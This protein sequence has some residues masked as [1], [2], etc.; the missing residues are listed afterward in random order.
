MTLPPGLRMSLLV[1]VLAALPLATPAQTVPNSGQI[2]QQVQ[3]HKPAKPTARPKLKVEQPETTPSQSTTPFQ[4]K[5]IVVEGASVV[6]AGTLYALVADGEGRRLT[7]AQLQ[8]L[9]GRIS[10]YYHAHGYLLARAIVPAQ[11]LDDGTVRLQVVEARY[12]G[13]DVDNR[14]RVGNALIRAILAPIQPGQVVTQTSLDRALLLLG[15]LPGVDPHATL[16][17]GS[18]AGTT[19][20]DVAA[21]PAPLLDGDVYMDNAGTRYTGRARIGADLDINSPMHH[22]DL[23]SFSV[24]TAGS[25]LNYGRAAYQYTFNGAGTRLG[26]GYSALRYKLSGGPVSVLDAH[27]TARVASAWLAQPIVRSRR[28]SLDARLQ[29]EHKRLR[30]DIGATALHDHRHS[31]S[32]TLDLYGQRQDDWLDG[33]ITRAGIGFT[34]GRLGFDDATAAATDAGTARTQGNYTRWNA[35]LSR[36]QQLGTGWR[37]HLGLR[38]QGSSDNLDSSEQFLLGGPHSVRGYDVGSVAGSNGWLGTVALRHDLAWGCAGRCQGQVFVDTGTVRVNAKRWMPGTNHQRL[39][40]AGLGF[41]WIGTRQWMLQVQVATPIGARPD[42]M[43]DG[44]RFWARLV[45][46]F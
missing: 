14:S 12:D 29:F 18:Q 31:D 16:R 24:L 30:D 37:L 32:W 40:A 21:A 2:L 13:V 42:A 45:K 15:D 25:G 33:G 5:R 6:D 23:L 19:R 4:V 20:V 44:A 28:G 26:A 10:A 34:H 41:D 38:G 36:L 8:A 9:A 27:G 39:G 35:H 22:G 17:P 7:L 3:P 43:H 1:L 11:T 46:G